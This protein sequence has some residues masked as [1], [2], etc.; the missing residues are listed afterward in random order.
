MSS[1]DETSQADQPAVVGEFKPGAPGHK[2]RFVNYDTQRYIDVVGVPGVKTCVD[3]GTLVA[4][5]M[6][7]RHEHHHDLLARIA[8]RVLGYPWQ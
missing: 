2:V 6:V 3:C 1:E 7:N 5:I 8:Q 4:T